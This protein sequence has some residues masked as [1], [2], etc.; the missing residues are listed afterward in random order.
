M[1]ANGFIVFVL[2]NGTNCD[3]SIP[4]TRI[5]YTLNLTV[6]HHFRLSRLNISCSLVMFE[7]FVD[8]R[9][10]RIKSH[11]PKVDFSQEECCLKVPIITQWL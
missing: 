3:H 5:V 2:L 8:T 1:K 9:S 10:V 11:L 7:I 6:V 4:R